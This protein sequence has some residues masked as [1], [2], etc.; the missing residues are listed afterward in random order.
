MT[1]TM[2][3]PQTTDHDHDQTTDH[4]TQTT[5][6]RP[7]TTDHRPQTTDHRQEKYE[8]FRPWLL[9]Q[10]TRA[11]SQLRLSRS[12]DVKGACAP[13]CSRLSLQKISSRD[14]RYMYVCIY[15]YI[16]IYTHICVYVYIICIY[17]LWDVLC[18][19]GSEQ[20]KTHITW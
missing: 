14:R 9:E 18:S 3:R 13:G 12:R 4:R 19:A 20:G 5:D 15:I 1:T 8:G 17:T 10:T 6:H 16:Y 2:T 7:Q 11:R